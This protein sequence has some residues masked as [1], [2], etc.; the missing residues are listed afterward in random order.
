MTLTLALSYSGK[1][2]IINAVNNLIKIERENQN[3]SESKFEQY[4]STNN[5]PDPEL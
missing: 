3:I 4:L 1:W 5:V 2:E